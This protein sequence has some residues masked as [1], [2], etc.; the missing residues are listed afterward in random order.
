MPR[1][2]YNDTLQKITPRTKRGK[3]VSELVAKIDAYKYSL[4]FVFAPVVAEVVNHS[5]P[6][7]ACQNVLKLDFYPF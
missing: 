7:V 2:C 6:P 5:V 4:L 1:T 3:Y